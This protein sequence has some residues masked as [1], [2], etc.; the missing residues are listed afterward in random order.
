M[1]GGVQ[2]S[3]G[4]WREVASSGTGGGGEIGTMTMA[5]TRCV[6]PPPAN[7]QNRYELAEGVGSGVEQVRVGF[8]RFSTG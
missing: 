6:I 2:A 1:R 4:V 3:F 7:V 5:P 8:K